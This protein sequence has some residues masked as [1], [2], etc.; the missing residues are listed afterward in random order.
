MIISQA[1]SIKFYKVVDK[2]VLNQFDNTRMNEGRTPNILNTDYC[3]L[4]INPQ[5][6]EYGYDSAGN[7]DII[8]KVTL[9][10]TLL[11]TRIREDG[12]VGVLPTVL[13]ATTSDAK[14]YQISYTITNQNSDI[15]QE[16]YFKI[17]NGV[18]NWK[19]E[20]CKVVSEIPRGYQLL[21]WRNTDNAFNMAYT[22]ELGVSNEIVLRMWVKSDIIEYI[23]KV[24]QDIFNNQTELIKLRSEVFRAWQLKVAKIPYYQIEILN[25]AMQHDSFYINEKQYTTEDEPNVSAFGDTRFAKLDITVVE[26]NTIGINSDDQGFDVDEEDTDMVLAKTAVTATFSDWTVPKG[27]LAAFFTVTWVSGDLEIAI[28]TAT[29]QDDVVETFN[30]ASTA[31]NFSEPTSKDLANLGDATLYGTISGT[32][33]AN[34]YMILIKNRQ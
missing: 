33:S 31:E 4:I 19:S 15:N 21:E 2:T 32:G 13:L 8:V 6:E 20:P 23:P 12:N 18:D 11:V 10:E 16:I 9:T 1:N 17:N 7:V 28:G 26:T 24:D 29:D 22:D 5:P 3:Q 30:I 27:Y 14:F 25:I 34:L